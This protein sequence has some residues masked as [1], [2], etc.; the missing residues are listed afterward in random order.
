[1]PSTAVGPFAQKDFGPDLQPLARLSLT[2]D[3]RTFLYRPTCLSPLPV[4]IAMAGDNPPPEVLVKDIVDKAEYDPRELLEVK[5]DY[6]RCA[7]HYAAMYATSVAVVELLIDSDQNTLL[8][9]TKTGSTPL[10]LAKER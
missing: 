10:A 8:F 5:D 3:S 7:L 1:M 9:E 6:S 2:N 4:L